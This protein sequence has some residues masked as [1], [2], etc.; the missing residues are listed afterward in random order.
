MPD[1][2][3][4]GVYW[5]DLGW[6]APF[7]ANAY[8]LVEDGSDPAAADQ[9]GP[10]VAPQLDDADVTLVDTGFPQD[11][12]PIRSE[13]ASLGLTVSDIDRVLLT[14]YD[15]DHV[16]GLSR[17]AADLDAP[18]FVGEDDL[19]LIEGEVLPSMRNHKGLFHRGLRRVFS[20]PA[21][22]SFR[23]VA[24]GDQI[25]EFIAFHTPGHNLGHTVYL[26]E[27][28]GAAMLG[29]L[30]WEDGGAFTIPVWLDSYDMWE[31]RESVERLADRIPSFEVACVGHGTPLRTGGYDA[32]CELAARMDEESNWLP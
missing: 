10:P 12:T 15:L 13:L 25:G 16:G 4:P 29:D 18:V 27:G 2:L 23:P 3:A 19:A 6:R 21:S 5:L 22:L 28:L 31:L 32:L 8:L 26:H 9:D 20:L 11:G 14:H 1:R 17:L 7:G 30:V 24:D